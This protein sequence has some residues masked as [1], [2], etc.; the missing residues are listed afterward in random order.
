MRWCIAICVFLWLSPPGS[1]A[2]RVP[3]AREGRAL[4]QVVIPPGASAETR[5]RA[6]ELAE[7]LQ[8]ITGAEFEVAAKG[9]GI[10]IGTDAEWPGHLPALKKE[11][12]PLLGRDDYLLQTHEGGVRI[13][14][15]SDHG[16]RNGVWDFFHRLGFR[17]FY[18]GEKWAIWPKKGELEIAVDTF[19]SPRYFTRKF[20]LPG[21]LL[22]SE[23]RAFQQWQVRNRAVSGFNLETGHAYNAIILRNPEHFEKHPQDIARREEGVPM[24][25]DPSRESVLRIAVE[26]SLHQLEARPDLH[27]VRMDPSDGGGWRTDSP[28]GSPSNQTVVLANHVARAIQ[29]RFPGR[30]VGIYAYNE[31]SPAPDREVDRNVI[32][33]IATSF[34]RGG[35]TVEEL[36]AAWQKKGAEIG[37]REYL[38]VW[39]WDRDLPGRSRASNLDY[40]ASTIPRFY[41]LG[42][43]YWITEG[44]A[45]W[46]AHGLGYYVASRLLWDFGET[47]EAVV[48]DFFTHAFGPAAVEM[49]TFH[50]YL[51]QENRPLLSDDLLGRMYRTLDAAYAKAESPEIAARLDDYLLHTRYVD[52]MFAFQSASDGE[53]AIAYEALVDFVLRAR[54]SGLLNTVAVVR[55]MTKRNRNVSTI[56]DWKTLVNQPPDT[57][58]FSREELAGLLRQGVADKA[59]NDFQPVAFSTELVPVEPTPPASAG[60]GGP[61]S[62]RWENTLYLHKPA[63]QG[64]FRFEVKGG[65]IYRNRGSIQLRLYSDKHA[66]VDEPVATAEVPPDQLAHSVEL[67]SPYEGIHRL[68]FNDGGALTVLSWPEGQRVA[69]PAS[70]DQ[71]ATL[72]GQ[73]DMVFYV[74]EGTRTVGGYSENPHGTVEVAN[75]EPVFDF[76]KMKQAGYFSIPVPEGAGGKWWRLRKARGAKLLLTTP[77][78]LFHTPAELL[79]PAETV[80]ELPL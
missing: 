10:C 6:Q 18:P 69:F 51:A 55:G 77:P 14:G 13:I 27:T 54:A 44:S 41:E 32:V 53:K 30:K 1:C 80:K 38:S 34:L 74:P 39:S 36:A 73:Y 24:K 11:L 58:A 22:R 49:R 7:G 25:L 19:E 40:V 12:S 15:R 46:V 37:I 43:R 61:V 68:E 4:V 42:A 3:L 20:F 35:H 63:G 2:E 8:R 21:A 64:A 60:S 75:G 16:T 29:P 31:H 56:V 79:L 47:R 23:Q 26:D 76:R 67:I 66:L 48:E 62:L 59:L 28:L 17:Q 57:R 71:K 52:L 9:E 72:W 65:E 78:Y 45:N 5:R 33:S 70:P 50:T